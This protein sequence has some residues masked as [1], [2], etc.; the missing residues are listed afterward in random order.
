MRAAVATLPSTFVTILGFIFILSVNLGVA[1]IHR[2]GGCVFLFLI[3]LAS[4]FYGW[5]ASWLRMVFRVGIGTYEAGFGAQSGT[6]IAYFGKR[7][8]MCFALHRVS[9]T[10][11]NLILQT[12]TS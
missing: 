9:I 1:I 8:I 6:L 4:A 11:D 3:C 2:C 12:S 5:Q 7:W 10:L